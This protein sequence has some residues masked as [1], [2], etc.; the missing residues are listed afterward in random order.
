M[1][2][3]LWLTA[4]IVSLSLQ[5]GCSSVSSKLK[6]LAFSKPDPS[7]PLAYL[8]DEADDSYKTAKRKLDN[9]EDTLLKFAKWR[10][11]LGDYDRVGKN[12]RFFD[13]LEKRPTTPPV[14][15]PRKRP[16]KKQTRSVK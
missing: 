6:S 3:G 12:M 4:L 2:N 8:P 14:P 10:E 13:P 1:K 5:A 7:D 16:P 9:G 15:A 11:D